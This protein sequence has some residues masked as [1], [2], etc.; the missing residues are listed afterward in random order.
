[1]FFVLATKKRKVLQA[2]LFLWGLASVSSAQAQ[3]FSIT[4]PHYE[5]YQRALKLEKPSRAQPPE[6]LADAWASGYQTVLPLLFYEQ[7]HLYNGAQHTMQELLKFWERY[8]KT[9]SKDLYVYAELQTQLALLH[10]RYRHY[11]SAAWA[12]RAAYRNTRRAFESDS[13]FSGTQKL[14]GVLLCALGA[15]PSE[16]RWITSIAGLSGN[17][18]E[19]IRLLRS[20]PA[21]DVFYKESLLIRILLI[22]LGT[23]TGYTLNE[24]ELSRMQLLEDSPLAN[25]LFIRRA[26][27]SHADTVALEVLAQVPPDAYHNTPLFHYLAAELYHR[28]LDFSKS[29]HHYLEYLRYCPTC[30]LSKDALYK[31]G[32]LHWYQQDTTGYRAYCDQAV[33]TGNTTAEADRYAARQIRNPMPGVNSLLSMGRYS[34]DGGYY[35]RADSLFRLAEPKLTP[36]ERLEHTYRVARLYELQGKMEKAMKAYA[37]VVSTS[38]LKGN[39]FGPNA[40][41]RIAEWHAERKN[42]SV[43]KEWVNKA[44]KFRSYAYEQSIRDKLKKLEKSF[45]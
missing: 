13:S 1:M 40:A 21:N 35:H 31:V 38:E 3:E 14:W 9:E 28:S 36:S 41:Y 22:D 19:G 5:Q 42:L 25:L 27:Q 32:L 39:Y 43:A 17:Y 16:Y 8:P 20:I 34:T 45:P 37:T 11:W 26:M 18:A 6:T 2:L 10:F 23:E 4:Y 24:E 44:K 7:E 30:D 33:V 12:F 15:V 29:E